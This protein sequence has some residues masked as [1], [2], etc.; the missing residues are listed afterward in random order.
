M[1][2]RTFDAKIVHTGSDA[3][4]HFSNEAYCF[5][6][7]MLAYA[8]GSR[9][10]V[11]IKSRRKPRSLAQNNT[12]HW[13]CGLIADDTGNDL[14]TVKNTVKAMF[15]KKPMVDKSGKE[16]INPETGEVAYFIQ[17][18]RNLSTVEMMEL[19]EN[20]R[21]FAAEWFGMDLPLPDENIKLNLK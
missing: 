3:T 21:L 18:T 6:E 17:D 7:L 9:V 15:L 8:D 13:Y 20:T 16:I 1:A 4:L 2:V 5:K 11:E 12:F 19:T 14:E 10:T